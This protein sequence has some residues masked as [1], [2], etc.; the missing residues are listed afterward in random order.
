MGPSPLAPTTEPAFLHLRLLSWGLILL[1]VWMGLLAWSGLQ[2]TFFPSPPTA[3]VYFVDMPAP[4]LAANAA[5]LLLPT[6]TLLFLGLGLAGLRANVPEARGRLTWRLGRVVLGPLHLIGLLVLF[7]VL[8]VVIAVAIAA[9]ALLGGGTASSAFLFVGAAFEALL[10]AFGW[11][12]MVFPARA[13]SPWTSRA[14]GGAVTLA[15]FVISGAALFEAAVSFVAAGV[16]ASML[17]ANP[18]A[19]VPPTYPWAQGFSALAAVAGLLVVAWVARRIV[20]RMG[21][22]SAR[23]VAGPA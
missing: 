6:C 12:L 2:T 22:S 7:I 14:E 23:A 5:L 20:H 10:I 15:V 1:A 18:R 13:I 3:P 16:G 9:V 11:C 8:T 17:L 4:L 19:D 21:R